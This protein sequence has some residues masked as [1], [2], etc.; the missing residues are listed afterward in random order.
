M[1]CIVS[2]IASFGQN[3]NVGIGTNTPGPSAILELSSSNQGL[4]LTRV[5][6]TASVSNPVNGLLIFSES[7]QKLYYY[8]GTTWKELIHTEADPQVNSTTTNVIP[9]WNGSALVDGTIQDNTVNVGIGIAPVANQ[10]LTVNGKTTTTNL[11]MTSGANNGF[12]LQ[13]DVSG[14]ANW[15]EFQYT[16][17]QQS[18][19]HNRN[20]YVIQNYHSRQ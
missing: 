20:P 1:I 19:Q 12:V 6:T 9:L 4:R 7:D 5:P 3:N 13:S 14:N 16:D 8:N 2:S 10:K 18:L 17:S 15:V 11:Q